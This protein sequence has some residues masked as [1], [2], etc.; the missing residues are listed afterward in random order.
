M[1]NNP[2]QFG[3]VRGYGQLIA[4]ATLGVTSMVEAMHHTILRVPPPFGTT[5]ERST[6]GVHRAIYKVLQR[7]SGLV[8][9]AI[10]QITRRTGSGL[11]AALNHLQPALSEP[12]SSCAR[13]ATLAIVNGVFGDHMQLHA[14]PLLINMSFRVG[15]HVLDLSRQ[16]LAGAIAAPSGK[17]LV[18]LHGHCMNDLQWCRNGHNHGEALAATHGFTPMYL[19][20]NSGL[21]ISQNGRA[22][23]DL[24]EQLVANWPVPVQELCIVG[25]SMGGLLARSAFHYAKFAKHCWPQKVRKLFF[26]GTPHHG[27]MLEQAGNLVDKA[28]E[29]SPYSVALSR[30]GKI[31]SAGT[32]DLRHGNVVDE[33]WI[34]HGRFTHF[35]DKRTITPLP[36]NVSC[37]AIAAMIGNA[38]GEISGR[39]IGDGLVP[40]PSALGRHRDP[41]R[42]LNIPVE[43]Q[44]VF[45]GTSHLA[46]LDSQD[47]CA[48]LQS[49]MG[50]TGS[51]SLRKRKP[52]VPRRKI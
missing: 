13:E 35:S 8:Y 47:V 2:I 14:N 40:V 6:T 36:P 26:V 29:I 28:L 49:W 21:H 22:L 33:D 34:G 4:D 48:Q 43:Q 11:D 44:R 41:R 19:R 25:Y 18:L 10:R 52:G 17:V 27:S 20:Y 42:V 23:S 51:C 1:R 3:D 45:Y 39:L 12:N 9:G 37:Y 7:G 50:S 32:T 31:R 30:L 38:H 46:L 15:G 24:L 16:A 5:G